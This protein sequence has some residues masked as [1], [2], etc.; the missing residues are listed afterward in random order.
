MKI[1]IHQSIMDGKKIVPITEGHMI[2]L[3]GDGYVKIEEEVPIRGDIVDGKFTSYPSGS[4][5]WFA[6]EYEIGIWTRPAGTD[7]EET[8]AILCKL[9]DKVPQFSSFDKPIYHDMK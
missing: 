5:G 1:P 4:V 7:L 8:L 6:A 3:K 9:V 2:K